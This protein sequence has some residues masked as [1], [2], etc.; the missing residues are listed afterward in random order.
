M[1]DYKSAKEAF[2]SDNPGSSIYT[3][4][5]ISSTAWT[6]YVLY[7]TVNNRFRSSFLLDYLTSAFPLLLSITL[8]ATSPIIY[9]LSILLISVIIYITSPKS[10]RQRS[11]N[12]K[13][14]K[15]KGSWLEESDSD[16]EIAESTSTNN[17]TN[18]TPIKLPSQIIQNQN[19][20]LTSSY[21]PNSLLDSPIRLSVE[22]PFSPIEGNK[23]NKRKLSP[24]PSPNNI[25]VNI[26]PTPPSLNA[27]SLSS[28]GYPSS[29]I[30][31]PSPSLDNTYIDDE[32]DKKG[33][34][35]FLS[36]YR[37]HMM[38]MTVHCILAVDF[39]IFPRWLG[40]CENYGTSL[41]DV[42]VGSFVFSLGLISIKSLT[43]VDLTSNINKYPPNS[44]GTQRKIPIKS[45]FLK[46]LIKVIKKS[47]PTLIL[48]FIRLL[49]VKG[50]E[51]PEHITEYGYHWNFFFTIGLLP[52]FGILLRPLRKW[53]RW[54]ILGIGIS[55]VHQII[56]SKFGLENY[57]ISNS[58][59]GLI[60]LNKEG[61]SSLPGY[62]SI[63]LLGLSTGEH[64]LKSSIMNPFILNNKNIN[65]TKE[66]YFKKQK[67]KLI[68]ELFS[69][70]L[71]W[72]SILGI[73]Y[74]FFHLNK[75]SR[76][77][78]NTPYVLFISSYN[79]LFLLGYL[80]LEYFFDL[81]NNNNLLELI[82]KNGLIIF[83][84]SNLFTGLINLILNS[85]YINNF[86]SILILISYS[87]IIC[88][89]AKII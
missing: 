48:G 37:A 28:T 12:D 35:P 17:S 60:G 71:T 13:D 58:R 43:L 82:N 21:S 22:D 50:I 45:N 4:I 41:M 53:I 64:I 18:N 88:I 89:I 24:Q 78:A 42:G 61:I 85:I 86:F 63:Y 44:P 36:V 15:S 87:F 51:Y 62:I 75:I 32:K 46:D 77:F 84:L 81:K 66:E 79:S 11:R 76:R 2:V 72:W 54:S 19:S 52:I 56:L 69:Y 33:R 39:K 68:L 20:A 7:A 57:L 6:S 10:R 34:L 47:T 25:T 26:L 14:D 65:E 29:R 27:E 67:I 40:K 70:T 49:M 80:I 38:I 8:F 16:E 3:I 9:N 59:N 30:N 31:S 23:L 1:S 55:L 5:A 74:L 83:L 73:Y